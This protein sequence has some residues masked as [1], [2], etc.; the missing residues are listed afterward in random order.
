MHCDVKVSKCTKQ[1]IV[2]LPYDLNLKKKRKSF[3][4]GKKKH[5]Q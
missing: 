3:K 1:H 2:G 5:A 4:I